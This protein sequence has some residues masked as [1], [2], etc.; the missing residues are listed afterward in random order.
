M[1]KE[2]EN[3]P[4]PEKKT[5]WTWKPEELEKLG[6]KEGLIGVKEKAKRTPIDRED[7]VSR[8]LDDVGWY[9]GR[10]N[11]L[12]SALSRMFNMEALG[13][14]LSYYEEK[15]TGKYGFDTQKKPK[16]GFTKN[17]KE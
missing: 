2:T 12:N 1:N 5:L 6:I 9:Q 7:F 13:F 16:V 17:G 4:K 3:Q 11:T 14:K 10:I 15:K 8:L